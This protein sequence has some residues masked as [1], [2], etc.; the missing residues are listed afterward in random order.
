V[1][2][3]ALYEWNK[4]LRYKGVPQFFS[5]NAGRV[6]QLPCEL[7]GSARIVLNRSRVL[8]GVPVHSTDQG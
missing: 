4:L 3:D 8:R 6:L 2:Y 7:Q 5:I 1:R